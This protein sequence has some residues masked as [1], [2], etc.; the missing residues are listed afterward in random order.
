MTRVAPFAARALG[1][2]CAAGMPALVLALA[3]AGCAPAI[4]GRWESPGG[5]DTM[6]IGSDGTGK[7]TIYFTFTSGSDQAVHVGQ[8]EVDWSEAGASSY[9]L[10]MSCFQSDTD[11]SGW[12]SQDFTMDCDATA[13]ADGSQASSLE[14]TAEGFLL[15]SSLTWSPVKTD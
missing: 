5:S 10:T 7:A 14:C 1:A 11:P 2:A 13:A 3:L 9:G 12:S 8:Y 6:T 15:G 4:A